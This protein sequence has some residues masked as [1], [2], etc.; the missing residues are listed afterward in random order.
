[1]KIKD[2]LDWLAR[3][4]GAIAFI[5]LVV[6]SIGALIGWSVDPMV[7][8]YVWVY[9]FIAFVL[10]LSFLTAVSR[11]PRWIR[12]LLLVPLCVAAVAGPILTWH[13]LVPMSDSSTFN[14]ERDAQGWAIGRD[15]LGVLLGKGPNMST[16]HVYAGKQS[17]ESEVNLRIDQ[18][19]LPQLVTT[20]TPV[21]GELVVAQ[22]YL[23]QDAPDNIQ[24]QFVLFDEI[25]REV[26]AGDID[27]FLRPGA[28][29]SVAWYSPKGTSFSSRLGIQFSLKWP[30]EEPIREVR[31]QWNGKVY[32]DAVEIVLPTARETATPIAVVTQTPTL[33][34]T[35]TPTDTPTQTPTH[36]VTPTPGHT[37]VVTGTVS[38]TPTPTATSS[39]TPSPSPTATNSPTPT[40]PPTPTDTPVAKYAAPLLIE[41]DNGAVF[42]GASVTL[43]WKWGLK[44]LGHNEFFAVR[45][46][47]EGMLHH[48]IHWENSKYEYILDLT[49][50]AEGTYFWNIAVVHPIEE[51]PHWE[52]ISTESEP[53][54][55]YVERPAPPT[56]TPAPPTPTPR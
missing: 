55:F 15:S 4:G 25:S 22:I 8:F 1:M 34:S 27:A 31:G 29:T 19:L 7:T 21:E 17:L 23:D 45:V 50:F 28:W 42:T 6:Q 9:A 11:F 18:P 2:F 14:F 26:V 52:A 53:R 39:P 37:I 13:F 30:L 51:E 48:S 3:I 49:H 16:S 44:Q 56:D 5:V 10:S 24:G 36:T 46:W 35:P 12:A 40:I 20:H 32:V 33:T 47:K 41:P 43:R 38:H 54:R